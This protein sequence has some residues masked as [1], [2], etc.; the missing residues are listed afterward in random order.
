MVTDNDEVAAAVSN[1]SDELEYWINKAKSSQRELKAAINM[2]NE[3]NN[4]LQKV[5]ANV[6]VLNRVVLSTAH[7][8][9]LTKSIINTRGTTPC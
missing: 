2:A 8:G 3:D 1:T 4:N 9:G 7:G 5:I 6:R